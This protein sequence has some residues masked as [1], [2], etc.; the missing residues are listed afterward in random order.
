MVSAERRVQLHAA[1]S[2]A[3]D[4]APSLLILKEANC[5]DYLEHR[6]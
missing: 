6:A 3:R 2:K 5:D 4:S 1:F